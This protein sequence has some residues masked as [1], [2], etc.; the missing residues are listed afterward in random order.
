MEMRFMNWIW[1][2]SAKKSKGK[3]R[4]N[5]GREKGRGSNLRPFAYRNQQQPFPN[6][7]PHRSSRII[8]IQQQS[9]F[10]QPFWHL[11]PHLLFPP[12]KNRRMMIQII[13]L[14]LPPPKQLPRKPLSHPQSLSHLQPHP[15]LS[16]SSAHPQFVAAK[17]LMLN[18]PRFC[19]HSII[20]RRRKTCE[21][22]EE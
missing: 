11:P 19:L 4:S 22:Q 14:Q 18:P 8:M 15:P 10:P 20:C 6:P 12:H 1:T 2:A 21:R 9:S 17:S 5:K 16:R 7:L 3:S 13:Q